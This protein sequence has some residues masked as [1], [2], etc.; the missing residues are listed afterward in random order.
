VSGNNNRVS[1]TQQDSFAQ[2]AGEKA[3]TV[4]VNLIKHFEESF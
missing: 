3:F 4:G 1:E 2:I